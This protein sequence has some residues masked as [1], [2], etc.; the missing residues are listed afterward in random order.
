MATE[1]L[2]HTCPRRPGFENFER[3]HRF[4]LLTTFR[5]SG[6]PISTPMWFA[7][8]G[9]RMFMVTHRTAAKLRRIRNDG[10]VMVGPCRSQG[11]PIAQAIAAVATVLDHPATDDARRALSRRYHL[12]R[13]LIERFLRRRGKGA[14]PVYLELV[15]VGS[16]P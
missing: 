7:M 5:S 4:A 2:P 11:K 16:N 1:A 10:R 14:R 15:A 3:R 9:S 12:P 13:S 8:S 6:T